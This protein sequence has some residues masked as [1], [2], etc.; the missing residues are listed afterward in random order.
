MMASMPIGRPPSPV[1]GVPPSAMGLPALLL[2]LPA[3]LTGFPASRLGFGRF[4][5]APRKAELAGTAPLETE[6]AGRS[7]GRSKGKRR[8]SRSG[9]EPAIRANRIGYWDSR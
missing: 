3:S 8:S 5:F 7:T 9:A 6:A 2:G 1:G 4:S